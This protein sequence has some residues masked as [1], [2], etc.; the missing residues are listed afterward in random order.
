MIYVSK[1]CSTEWAYSSAKT[2]DDPFNQV[3]LDVL[4]TDPDG[5]QQTVPAFWAGEN[6]WKVRYASSKVGRQSYRTVCSDQDNAQLHGQEGTIE[7]TPYEGGNRLLK[8]GPLRVSGDGRHFEHSDGT[9]FFW[10][11]DTWWLGFCKKLKWPEDF[12]E[13]TADRVEKGFSLIQIVAGMYPDMDP[14]D[15]RGVNEAGF[16]WEKDFTTINPYYF[17]M[18]D[19]RIAHLIRSGLVPCIVACWGY[20]L[21]VAGKEVLKKHWRNLIARYG[22]YPVVWCT[23]GEALMPYYVSPEMEVYGKMGLEERMKWLPEDKRRDWAEVMRYIREI[24][25]YGHPLTIHPTRIGRDQVDD[26]SL[27]DFEM[28]QTGHDDYKTLT[29]APNMI[30]MEL[31]REPIM[32]VLIAETNYDGI[33]ESSREEIQ[34]FLFWAALLTGAGGHTYGANGIWQVNTKEKP[35]GPSPHG[36]SWGNLP[37]DEAYRLPGSGQLGLAKK[38]L[39]RYEWW[40]FETHPEWV[41][42]H[43][44]PEDRLAPYVAGVPGKVRVVFIPGEAVRYAINGQMKMVGLEASA[45]YHTFYFDPKTATE[46]DQPS[47]SADPGGDYV[48]PKPPILQDWVFVLEG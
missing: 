35:H 14:F 45:K 15:E 20:F 36:I 29:N 42:P 7:V 12:K 24:D 21:E 13:L 27:M 38:L 47:A 2:Y 44:T 28:I 34:R 9:P 41:E 43:Q 23:A 32:P 33:R 4:I 31:S 26:A 19:L 25:P 30:E 37:W 39:E 11:G 22:A 5:T 1:N 10:L 48:L 8:Q 40:R 18:A 17:D 16:A 3:E 6:T 46:Y